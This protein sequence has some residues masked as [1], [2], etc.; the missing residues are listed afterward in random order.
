MKILMLTVSL[1]LS[2]AN[3]AFAQEQRIGGYMAYLGPEDLTNSSGIRLQN[4]AAIVAQ[5][6]ANY[7]RFGIRHE[8]DENDPWFSSRGHRMAIPELVVMSDNTA[9]IIVRQGALVAVS[10]FADA[11]GQMT[12][13]RV[14]IPG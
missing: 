1:A 6:R 12:S 8:F 5:D 11:T 13:M 10:I 7:H 14:E 4:A 2:G 3:I 9:K